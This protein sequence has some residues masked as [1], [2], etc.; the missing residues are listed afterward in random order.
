[1]THIFKIQYALEC[2]VDVS[3]HQE[4]PFL[5]SSLLG[6]QGLERYFVQTLAC[7]EFPNPLNHTSCELRVFAK[8]LIGI[9]A[10][11][12]KMK[13]PEPGTEQFLDI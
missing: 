2:H 13:I 12:Q 5:P 9:P 10:L 4:T 3:K 7:W 8:R 11:S 6:K 1:M